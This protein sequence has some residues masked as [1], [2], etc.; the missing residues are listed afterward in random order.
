MI[1]PLHPTNLNKKKITFSEV[2]LVHG[3]ANLAMCKTQDSTKKKR[4][5]NWTTDEINLYATVLADD[6]ENVSRSLEELA[7]KRSANNPVFESL[8]KCFDRELKAEEFVKANELN[9]FKDK[10]GNTMEYEDL[11]TSIQKLRRKYLTLKADWRK[12][13]DTV[14]KGSGVSPK[15]ETEWYKIM[16]PIFS[17]TNAPLELTDSI[18]DTLFPLD[19]DARAAAEDEGGTFSDSDSEEE[20]ERMINKGGKKKMEKSDKMFVNSHKKKKLI[21]IEV[22][23]LN[24]M[25]KGLEEIAKVM[26]DADRNRDRLFLEHKAEEAKRNREHELSIARIMMVSQSEPL[27]MH[28]PITSPYNSIHD[29]NISLENGNVAISPEQ[30][31]LQASYMPWS[32]IS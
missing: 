27:Q 5:R 26:I 4:S 32:N 13:N 29:Y 14:K 20:D 3:E 1:I 12:I 21:R 24:R 2:K 23:G 9:N 17:E 6:S 16:N 11:D 22:Q 7:L 18:D 30:S 15:K 8:K 31:T 10:Y 28:P 25:V 19:Y